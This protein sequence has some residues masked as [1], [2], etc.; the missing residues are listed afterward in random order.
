MGCAQKVWVASVV[1]TATLGCSSSEPSTSACSLAENTSPTSTVTG[2]CALL[3]RD[4]SPC[5]DARAAAGITGFWRRFSCRVSLSVVSSGDRSFIRAVA[6]SQPDYLTPYFSA[7]NPCYSESTSTLNPN[8]LATQSLAIEFP[9]M[10][11]TAGQ[12]MPLGT[13]GLAING[14][15]IFSN[16]ARPGDDIYQEVQT[17]DACGAHP[18]ANGVYHYHGEPYAVSSSDAELIGTLRDGYPVYGR[19]DV[20]E[21]FPT[22]DERGGHIGTTPDSTTPVYHYHLNQ[23]TSS[24]PA[25]RGEKQWFITSGV[26]RG[27]VG[28]CVGC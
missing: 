3:H 22:L 19:L 23:Q 10:T 21:S 28:T 1:A 6:D 8:K 5:D 7:T 13:V 25:T 16:Q 20:D 4:T 26:Y 17:F 27:S 12:A 11:D 18:T 24:N 14:V 15:A 2:G 9:V